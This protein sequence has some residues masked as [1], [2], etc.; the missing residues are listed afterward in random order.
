MVIT[1]NNILSSKEE[2]VGVDR[3]NP[4]N[5]VALYVHAMTTFTPDDTNTFYDM[6]QFLMGEFQPLSELAKQNIKDRMLQND[7][8]KYIGKS[9]MSG[10]IPAN[11]YTPNT[12]YSVEVTANEYTDEN[13]GFKRLFVRSGGA[14]SLR[15]ITLRLAKDGNYYIWSDSY[16][17]LLTDIRQPES[18]NP[19]A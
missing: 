5:V 13:E 8:Y 1:F 10:A 11:D 18:T 16:M 6:L 15:P 19:W 4:A 3:S 9:Y 14:D 17:G 12:P 7:K 2:L